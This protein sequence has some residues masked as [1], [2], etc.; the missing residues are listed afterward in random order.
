SVLDAACT[1]L[2]SL[3]LGESGLAE[4]WTV[5]GDLTPAALREILSAADLLD[6]N[7]TPLPD[8]TRD[9]LEAPRG[10]ALARLCKAWLHAS[11]VNDLRYTPGLVCEGEWRNDPLRARDSVL[12]FLAA[13][14]QGVWWNLNNLISDVHETQPDFQRSAGEYDSWFI[15]RVESEESLA[16][17]AHW[18]DVDGA[19]LRYLISGPLHA[20][21]V[22]DL[23]KPAENEEVTAF[24]TSAW[25]GALL[26]GETPTGLPIEDGTVQIL[27]DGL[28][29][30][31][32]RVPRAVRYQLARFCDWEG[33]DAG[34][35]RYRITPASLARARKQGLR[36][37][38][39]ETLLRR[40][41]S[42]PP[43]P[44]LVQALNR[45]DA[46]GTQATLQTV[47]ILRV[48]SPEMMTALRGSRAARFLSELLGPTTAVIK[49]GAQERLRK[50]LAEM[51]YLADV[52]KS[53]ED[54]SDNP[55]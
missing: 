13:I 25:S 50:A 31:P 26:N 30:V 38:H 40:S 47:T 33:M 3:R 20:L 14:P 54:P 45:W 18:N 49:P 42:Q 8:A 35:F 29:R 5:P 27:P 28:L 41:G 43:T 15:R 34:E 23:A 16:G 48:T 11:S 53:D 4:T 17:F 37:G 1:L 6:E 36:P 10:D 7:G 55:R 12:D 2:A 52:I 9:F 22:V 39:L 51:G 46:E 19:L 21:G 32:L 44:A 24:R